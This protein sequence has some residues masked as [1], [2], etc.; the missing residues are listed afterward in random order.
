M[1]LFSHHMRGSRKHSLLSPA[2]AF[3]PLSVLSIALSIHLRQRCPDLSMCT[4]VYSQAPSLTCIHA[5]PSS[6]TSSVICQYYSPLSPSLLHH[7]LPTH[8]SCFA[9]LC[10]FLPTLLI[11]HAHTCTLAFSS[12]PH[13]LV[14]TLFCALSPPI[15]WVFHPSPSTILLH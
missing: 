8:H 1:H 11:V 9:S 10:F 15:H 14:S 2:P 13:P 5:Q 4:R 6:S 3:R 12:A 7:A